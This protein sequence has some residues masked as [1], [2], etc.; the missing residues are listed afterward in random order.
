MLDN[1]E[2]HKK[3]LR[4]V[5]LFIVQIVS[6][7]IFYAKTYFNGSLPGG[8]KWLF[9]GAEG[10]VKITTLKHVTTSSHKFKQITSHIGETLINFLVALVRGSN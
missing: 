5:L 10:G 3:Q 7:L 9:G 1:V 8:D 6:R 2:L 4:F